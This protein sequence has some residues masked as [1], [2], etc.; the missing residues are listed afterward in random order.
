MTDKQ[1][2]AGELYRIDLSLLVLDCAEDGVDPAH[3]VRV[4]DA[5]GTQGLS[6]PLQFT[7]N[8]GHLVVTSSPVQFLA[9][10]SLGMTEVPAIFEDV[11]I[12]P[13]PDDEALKNIKHNLDIYGEEEAW[14]G[15]WNYGYLWSEDGGEIDFTVVG[16]IFDDK[17]RPFL[18]KSKNDILEIAPGGGRLTDRKSVV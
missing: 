16:T 10:R 9:V 5:I 7:R 3:V 12:L 8:D 18:P 13:P 14:L 6:Q 15:R 1:Y 4:A 17:I 11:S 2:S